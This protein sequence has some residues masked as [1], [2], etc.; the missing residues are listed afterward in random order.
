MAR[1]PIQTEVKMTVAV[2]EA[3][4]TVAGF[5][6]T[7]SYHDLFRKIDALQGV[8]RQKFTRTLTLDEKKSYIKYC[9]ERDCQMVTGVFR[10]FEPLGSTLEMTAMAYDGEIPTKY[11]LYDGQTYTIPKYIAKRFENEFQGVGT[12]YPTHHHILDAAGRPIIGVAKKNRRFGFSS[13]DFQ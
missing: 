1:K 5:T 9:R 12:W 8:D 3:E 7:T 6:T 2:K 11:T 13:M 4:T 10:S